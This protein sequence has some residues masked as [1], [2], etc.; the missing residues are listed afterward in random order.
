MSSPCSHIQD[1]YRQRQVSSVRLPFEP[2]KTISVASLIAHT[3]RELKN[4][5]CDVNKEY[6][7]LQISSYI[8][9]Y[10]MVHTVCTKQNIRNP[11]DSI[12]ALRILLLAS[13]DAAPKSRVTQTLC[14]LRILQL[15]PSKHPTSGPS[16]ISR[17][18]LLPQAGHASSAILVRPDAH[19]VSAAGLDAGYST[20]LNPGKGRTRR[21]APYL[22]LLHQHLL[23]HRSSV[24]GSRKQDYQ[25]GG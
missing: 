10:D 20:Y 4:P 17:S 19:A 1:L 15:Y 8:I 18:S 21:K 25:C 3:A 14:F 23:R 22:V 16:N 2:C 7:V 24:A 9:T 5:Y 13:L 11:A 6:G 12:Q